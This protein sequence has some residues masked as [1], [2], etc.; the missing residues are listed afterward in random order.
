MP[1]NEQ[2]GIP[3][4]GN[5]KRKVWGLGSLCEG[6]KYKKGSFVIALRRVG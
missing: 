1:E 5:S 4:K 6:T 2:V 3:G